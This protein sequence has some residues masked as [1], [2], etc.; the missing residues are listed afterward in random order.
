MP[1]AP[2]KLNT[3]ANA[4]LT[5]AGPSELYG[6]DATANEVNDCLAAL[7]STATGKVWREWVKQWR[8][9]PA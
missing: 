2:R 9:D 4:L 8:D 6:V 1:E 5:C 3:L 7:R